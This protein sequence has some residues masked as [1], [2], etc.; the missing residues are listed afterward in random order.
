M[1]SPRPGAWDGRAE[2]IQAGG[3]LLGAKSV[4]GP[5]FPFRPR[6][7]H[8]AIGGV[9]ETGS[10]GAVSWGFAATGVSGIFAAGVVSKPAR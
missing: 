5:R 8:P 6:P 7:P 10:P 4:L 2:N 3:D 1:L 9:E